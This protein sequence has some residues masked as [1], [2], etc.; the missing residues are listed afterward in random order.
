MLKIPIFKP[1]YQTN[2]LPD[3][4]VLFL[5]EKDHPFLLRG[6]VYE[7]LA[8]HINGKNTSEEIIEQLANSYPWMNLE[9]ALLRLQEKGFIIEAPQQLSEENAAFW[10]AYGI[11][12]LDIVTTKLAQSAIHLITIGNVQTEPLLENLKNLNFSTSAA[13]ATLNVIVTDDYLAPELVEYNEKALAS[14]K[15]W[16]IVKYKGIESWIGPLFIPKETGC[17]LCL[18]QRIKHHQIEKTWLLENTKNQ[19]PQLGEKGNL[20]SLENLTYN[21]VNSEITKYFIDP[22]Q[23]QLIGKVLTLDC[24]DWQTRYHLLHREPHCKACGE[25]VLNKPQPVHLTE[26]D[27]VYQTAGYRTVSPDQLL[28]KFKHFI[29]PITGFL[30][31]LKPMHTGKAYIYV[32]DYNWL[33]RPEDDPVMQETKITQFHKWSTGKGITKKQAKASALCEALERYCGIFQGNEPR[34]QD[35]FQHLQSSAIHPNDCMLYSDKQYQDRHLLNQK[36]SLYDHV[37][38]PFNPQA[39]IEWTPVWS[40]TQQQFRY[41]PT[42]YVYSGYRPLNKNQSTYCFGDSN[43][44]AAGYTREEA[45]LQGFFEL[46]ERDS[47]AIWWY[48]RIQRPAI[49]L[50][51]FKKASWNVLLNHYKKMGRE[52]WALDI[53]TDLNIPTVVVISRELT[54]PENIC[55][56]FG[57]HLDISIAIERALTEMQ[58][59]VSLVEQ[60]QSDPKFL[61]AGEMV[62]VFN[63]LTH[64]TLTQETYLNPLSQSMR[65]ANDYTIPVFKDVLSPIQTC[66][67]IIENK[68][69]ELLIADQ[70]RPEIGLGVAKVIVPGLRHFWT[71]F[72]P[73]RLYD[74]PVHLGLLKTPR[75]ENQ[76]NPISIF[77]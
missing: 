71:R 15:P 14:G 68:G 38:E 54:S 70:T 16:L 42:E 59:M 44:C 52:T 20:S 51:S 10:S 36:P 55:L 4:G 25:T 39:T 43:G 8:S 37:P 18:R 53:T 48:N 40:L 32:T 41:L 30:S 7:A 1:H 35:C 26:Q 34:I 74:V 11:Q 13:S 66:Q 60:L 57:C 9:Y 33:I 75:L 69:M 62:D 22:A 31:D 56:G 2:I 24:R 23:C 47:I 61:D 27:I 49:A 50:S 21:L 3:K 65:Q 6:K 45:V 5:A 46:V 77:L 67:S 63:W 76:L 12:N 72:A 19:K 64:A 29:S 58:Q 17:Y 28:K 73:G